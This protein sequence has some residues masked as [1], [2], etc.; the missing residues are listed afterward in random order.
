M[1]TISYP[2]VEMALQRVDGASFEKF[3]HAFFAALTG[4]N[5][6][7]LGGVHDG[8]ADAFTE[9]GVFDAGHADHF[10]QA[11]V[12]KTPRSKIRKT[13]SRLRE[14][15][16]TPA[17]LT[18][19]T[20]VV[21]QDIDGEEDL[22]GAEL[23]LRVRIRD[24]KY[25]LSHINDSP[26]TVQAFNSYLAPQLAFL[27]DIGGTTLLSHTPDLPARSL[28]VFLGQEIERRRGDTQLLEAVTDSLILWAMEGT[29]PDKGI[30]VTRDEIREK[31]EA[32]LPAARHFIRGVMDHR[33]KALSSKQGTSGREVRWHK[34]EDKFCLPY[35]TRLLVEQEN[36]EDESLKTQVSDIFKMRVSGFTIPDEP[37]ALMELV[38]G[39]CHRTLEITFE[40]QGLEV[41]YYFAEEEP[42][43]Y[44]TPS[45]SENV[46][47]AMEALSV[48]SDKRQLVK[49]TSMKVLRSTFYE[50]T[51]EERVYLSKLSR[52]YTLIFVLK[53]EPKIVEYFRTMS[54][55]FFIYRCGPNY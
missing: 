11:S 39:T 31:I 43:D 50:S 52:T 36:V 18:Y 7:P 55:D 29:D 8:G 35:E 14:F 34:K 45:I 25:I 28:C 49:E 12:E 33:L 4:E 23:S 2:L 22:L 46:D 17:Q 27:R 40:K 13:V 9:G 20:S 42:E 21:V 44:V 24:Q 47:S 16:R 5:F 41:A 1:E 6:V 3:C 53:N 32:A 10:W 38:V 19:C 15:G 30:F 37:D 51:E 48:G 26:Q 54:R